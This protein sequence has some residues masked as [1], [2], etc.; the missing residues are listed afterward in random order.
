MLLA[1]SPASLR[2]T[3][4]LLRRTRGLGLADCLALEL[5]LAKRV[6]RSADFAE[7]VRAA[8][9]D[10]DRAPVWAAAND[11]PGA[12]LAARDLS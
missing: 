10:R 1:A 5:E 11:G 2:I 6:T 9:V 8:L 7:G 12:A 3:F 4:D